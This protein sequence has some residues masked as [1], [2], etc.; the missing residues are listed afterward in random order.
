MRVSDFYFDLPDELIARY[1][2]LIAPL[3][4]YYNLTAKM[5]RLPTAL[6]LISLIKFMKATY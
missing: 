1:P 5:V 4:A 2:K 3:V 6:L